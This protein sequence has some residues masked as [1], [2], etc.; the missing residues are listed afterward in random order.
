MN[1]LLV[2]DSPTDRMVIEARLRRAFPKANIMVADDSRQFGKCLQENDCDVVV[3][4]YWLGWTDG[5]SVLQRV[6]ERWPNVRTIILTGN[7][8]EEVVASAFNYGLYHYLLKPEGFD[9]LVTVTRAAFDDKRLSDEH[10]IKASIFDSIPDAVFGVDTKGAVM[11]MNAQAAA[12]LGYPP[13]EII[14]GDAEAI[15][16]AD[17]R[18]SVRQQHKEIL[19]GKGVAKIDAHLIRRG[20]ELFK[21]NMTMVPIRAPGGA[22]F[23]V[24]CVASPSD[25]S[26]GAAAI[27]ASQTD[28]FRL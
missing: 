19:E 13:E 18:A 16:P 17:A 5:L 15:F 7:G 27:L 14:G 10:Q 11:A 6:R 4:D 12:I 3:T 26:A 28:G 2:E 23:G 21:V 9:E 8:G 24:A 1:L 20:G 22:A 25:D